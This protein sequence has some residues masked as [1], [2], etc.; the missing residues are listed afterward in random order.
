MAGV[1]KALGLP[2]RV[3]RPE[4]PLPD[5]ERRLAGDVMTFLG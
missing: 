2:L 3:V 1:R 5:I 4:V